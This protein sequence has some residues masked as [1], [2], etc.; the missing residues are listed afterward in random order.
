MN[1]YR[2]TPLNEWQI[3]ALGKMRATLYTDATTGRTYVHKGYWSGITEQHREM[4]TKLLEA[5]ANPMV[6]TPTGGSHE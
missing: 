6:P 5:Y 2:N 3:Y 1:D 4:L